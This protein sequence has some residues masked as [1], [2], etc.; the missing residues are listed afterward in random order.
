MDKKA[1]RIAEGVIRRMAV[2]KGKTV[3]EI[4]TEIKKAML[5]GL[6]SREAE[7]QAFWQRVPREGELPTPEEIVAFL[8]EEA[9]G[10]R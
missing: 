7:V 4:R 2:S 1:L 8:A 3:E 9:K 5:V 10:R 6:C